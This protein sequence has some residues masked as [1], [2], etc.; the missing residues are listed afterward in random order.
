MSH[1]RPAFEVLDADHDGKISYDDLTTFCTS[2]FLNDNPKEAETDIVMSMIHAADLNRDGFVEYEE[3]ERVLM[4][5][6]CKSNSK[7]GGAD[8]M[9]EAF[10][11]MDKDGDGRLSRG[12]LRCYMEWAGLRASEDDIKTMISFGGGDEQNGLTFDGLL[13]I[14]AADNIPI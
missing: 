7:I 14:L 13:R 5:G 12:D 10:R 1:F 4:A 6:P 3:F 11:I 9:E 2:V 8:F